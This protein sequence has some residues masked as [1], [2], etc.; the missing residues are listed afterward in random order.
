MFRDYV[1]PSSHLLSADPQMLAFI[2]ILLEH[3]EHPGFVIRDQRITRSELRHP[4]SRV[5]S[6]SNVSSLSR[7]IDVS[8][9]RFDLP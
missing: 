9:F 7:D 8:R 3:L 4:I 1:A 2:F 6:K 5:A